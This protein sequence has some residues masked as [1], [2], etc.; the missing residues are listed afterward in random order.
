MPQADQFLALCRIYNI[1][2]ALAV[3]TD[4]FPT[5][6]DPLSKEGRGKVIEFERIL[7]AS[8]LYARGSN[9]IPYHKRTRPVYEEDPVSAGTGQFL[10]S[11]DY[12]MTEIDDDV[13]DCV[14]FGVRVAGDSMEPAIQ[15]GQIV[16]VQQQPTLENGEIGIFVLNGQSFVKK[17]FQGAQ[18]VSL[19]SLNPKY[20]PISIHAEDDLRVFG[21]VIL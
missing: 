20:A 19:I 17:L 1:H 6:V 11:P 7:V 9:V 16:W 15:N 10:D 2:D 12:T 13:P 8:K 14:N 4:A 5:L 18:G 3:F 21:K